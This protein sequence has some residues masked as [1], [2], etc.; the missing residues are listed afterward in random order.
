MR[1]ILF[2]AS[3]F[4]VLV[5]PLAAAEIPLKRFD[6]LK[7]DCD[8]CHGVNGVSPTPDQVP[9]IAGKSER[10]LVNRLLAFRAG[11][12]R[13]ETMFL[14]GNELTDDEVKAVARYYS[15]FRQR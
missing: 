1:A 6:E 4:Q 14:M 7:M 15:R 8:T 11:K 3:I 2:L 9:S 13:H 12:R 10:F 5:T